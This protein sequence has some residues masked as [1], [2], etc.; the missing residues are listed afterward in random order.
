MLRIQEPTRFTVVC[1]EPLPFWSNGNA[2]YAHTLGHGVEAFMILG[3][4]ILIV[5]T[6]PM[7]EIPSVSGC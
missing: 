5:S 1:V 7:T 6:D 4:W 3:D 2:R